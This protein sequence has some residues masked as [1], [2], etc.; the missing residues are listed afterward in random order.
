MRCFHRKN[1]LY[2]SPM[3]L[4]TIIEK[5]CRF[6]D[7]VPEDEPE[8]APVAPMAVRRALSSLSR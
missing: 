8:T 4:E 3:I 6:R 7:A 5:H 1:R 2:I